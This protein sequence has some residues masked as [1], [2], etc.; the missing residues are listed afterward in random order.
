MGIRI[1]RFPYDLGKSKSSKI[2]FEAVSRARSATTIKKKQGSFQ[3]RF[4]ANYVGLA[5]PA[6]GRSSEIF[7]R[8]V[9]A[10]ERLIVSIANTF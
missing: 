3:I 1:S 9:Y 2:N 5:S 7:R 8:S 10:N 6:R 4:F